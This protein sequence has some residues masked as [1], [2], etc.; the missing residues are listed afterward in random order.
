[1]L[2]LRGRDNTS[3]FGIFY[4]AGLPIIFY[5]VNYIG[6]YQRTLCFAQHKIIYCIRVSQICLFY[7]PLFYQVLKGFEI[8][9]AWFLMLIT[10]ACHLQMM[11]DV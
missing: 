11:F 9:H 3:C 8:V 6:V 1:M 7:L 10:F 5:L 2:Y 4:K